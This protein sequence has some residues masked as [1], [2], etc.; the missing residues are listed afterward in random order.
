M[1]K[2]LVILCILSLIAMVAWKLTEGWRENRKRTDL[3]IQT[4]DL[5]QFDK[6]VTVWGDDWLGYLIFRSRH[7]Q[8][9]LEGKGIGYRFE[10]KLDFKE[11]YNGLAN[12]GCDIVL[13]TIDSYLVNAREVNYPGVITFV[14]DES[15]GGDAIIGKPGIASLDDLNKPGIKGAFVEFSPSEFLLKSQ[16]SHFKLDGILPQVAGFRVGSA[17]EAHRRLVDGSVDFAVLWEPFTSAALRDIEGSQRLIDTSQVRGVIIDV[18]I[19]SRSMVVDDPEMLQAVTDA[20]FETLH[21]YF[22]HSG[23]F[24]QLA[25]SDQT[26]GGDMLSGIEFA[27]I[28]DNLVLSG[29]DAGSSGRDLLDRIANI[30]Q[31]LIDVGDLPGDPFN[32]NPRGIVNSRYLQ[33]VKLEN[34]KPGSTKLT[35]S[36]YYR[37]LSE[38]DWERLAA[39]IT[40]TLIDKPITFRVGQSRVDEEFQSDLE[41]AAQKLEHYPEHRVIIQAHVSAGSDPQ[42]DI[43]LSQQ[44]ADAIK[45]AL[46]NAGIADERILSRGMG[47]SEPVAREPGESDRAWKRRCRRARIYLAPEE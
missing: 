36:R 19:A 24:H 34:A 37:N 15:F 46:V 42:I 2:T 39:N 3:L 29:A 12:G 9:L 21:Y 25:S 23:E 43:E 30:T 8:R 44:R 40:G 5:Q 26:S 1:K 7:F 16:I 32:G 45:Q 31:I 27:G 11:R 38:A 18:A 28:E 22:A 33:A 13:G 17:E 35:A 14:I 20:Y 10:Q 4:S 47:S 6:V 41:A